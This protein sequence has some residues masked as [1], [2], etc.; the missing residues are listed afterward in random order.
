[1]LWKK[2]IKKNSNN[3]IVY[4][5][6][7]TTRRGEETS[8][9]LCRRTS[10]GGQESGRNRCSRRSRRMHQRPWQRI[11][12]RRAGRRPRYSDFTRIASTVLV[13][14]VV[15]VG[16]LTPTAVESSRTRVSRLRNR[17]PS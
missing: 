1:M 6:T 7:T 13:A 10:V 11:R 14:V 8:A 2:K 16:H 3:K 17:R 12:A 9:R 4:A 5:A 15:V